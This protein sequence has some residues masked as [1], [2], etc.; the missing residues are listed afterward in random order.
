MHFAFFIVSPIR[1]ISFKICSCCLGGGPGIELI[2]YP[3]RP[4]MSLCSQKSMN[5]S[6]WKLEILSGRM[7]LNSVKEFNRVNLRIAEVS[8]TCANR[9]QSNQ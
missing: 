8:I 9:P 2:T 5:N 1:L 7:Q 4:S 3:G 6:V